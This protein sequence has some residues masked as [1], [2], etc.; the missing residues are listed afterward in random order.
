[1]LKDVMNYWLVRFKEKKI[2]LNVKLTSIRRPSDVF[3]KE[4]PAAS[5][6]AMVDGCEGN[7]RR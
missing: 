6:S 4:P 2:D 5:I 7:L 3:T 1:M